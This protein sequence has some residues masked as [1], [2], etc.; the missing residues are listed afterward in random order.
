MV[1]PA[2]AP[3]IVAPGLPTTSVAPV[4]TPRTTL[5]PAPVIETT[6]PTARSTA[7]A[8]AAPTPVRR[9]APSRTATPTPEPV[10]TASRS[11]PAPGLLAARVDATTGG[12]GSQLAASAPVA[13]T[14][15]QPEPTT[16]TGVQNGTDEELLL[17]ALASL[18]GLGAAGGIWAVRRRRKSAEEGYETEAPVDHVATADPEPIEFAPV[19]ETLVEPV[20]EAPRRAPLAAVPLGEAKV[21]PVGTGSLVEQIDYTKPAGYYESVVDRGPTPINP[22]VTRR[23]RM[24]RAH[25][26]DGQLENSENR[27]LSKQRGTD[28]AERI[29]RPAYV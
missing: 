15:A 23:K 18:L 6:T 2:P 28:F 17:G 8:N 20:R 10:A 29:R 1:D 27:R 5:A 26:L 13:I 4:A 19:D 7:T 21:Q 25:F 9:A 3:A 11:E 16:A 22:F 12:N 24:A 14:N